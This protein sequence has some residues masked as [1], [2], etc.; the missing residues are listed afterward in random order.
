MTGPSTS[1]SVIYDLAKNPITFDFAHF[2]A[3][4]RLCFAIA[5]KDPIFYLSLFADSWRNDTPRELEYSLDDRIWRLH[6]LITPICS[7]TPAI[8][9]YSVSL[10]ERG[11]LSDRTDEL[12]VECDGG[13]Y[14]IQALI[15]TFRKAGFDPHLFAAPQ[16]AR[17]YAE[18]ILS[19]RPDPVL[20]SIRQS[21]FQST[22]NI[23]RSFLTA[24]IDRLM[25][26]GRSVFVIPDQETDSIRRDLPPEVVFVD[27][28]S[29]NLPLRLALHEQAP[30]SICSASGPTS[31][32]SLAISKPSLVVVHPTNPEVSVSRPEY[33]SRQGWEVGADQPL[34]W[35]PENQIW[36]W[37]PDVSAT[38]ACSAAQSLW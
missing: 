12:M 29:F 14:S 27:E 21:S 23:P 35:T 30:V 8:I 26:L 36:L 33:L 10:D 6:N 2:L 24:L 20:V 15:P 38:F 28:A 32:I 1:N 18:R 17:Q 3:Y 25:D 11:R 4:A 34:P 16:V 13:V 31:F 22:R 5:G 9:G 37:D 7:V 19:T